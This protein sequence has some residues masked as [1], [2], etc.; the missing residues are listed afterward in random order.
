MA[1]YCM[2]NVPYPDIKAECQNPR[3]AK[4]LMQLCAGR[5]SELTSVSQYTYQEIVIRERDK[6]LSEA[7]ECIALTEM[8]HFHILTELIHMLG[9]DPKLRANAGARPNTWW[10]GEYPSYTNSIDN[11]LNDNI[12]AEKRAAADYRNA[13]DYI[14]DKYVC[15]NLERIIIDEEYHIKI[16]NAFKNQTL[17]T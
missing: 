10:S 4:V 13:I 16:F 9:G 8:K 14:N 5:S 17:L 1:D 2:L 6:E 3:Y 7:L 12:Q 15:E 11:I